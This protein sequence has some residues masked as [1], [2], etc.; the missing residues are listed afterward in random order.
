MELEV[1]CPLCDDFI[2]V[3]ID[4]SK[5]LEMDGDHFFVPFTCDCGSKG[6]IKIELSWD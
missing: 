5:V 2:D 1:K 3:E 4:D 6:K